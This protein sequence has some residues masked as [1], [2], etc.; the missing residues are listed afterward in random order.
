MAT[1]Q[2]RDLRLDHPQVATPA[3]ACAGRETF[4]EMLRGLLLGHTRSVWRTILPLPRGQCPASALATM[5][6]IS[7]DVLR[8]DSSTTCESLRASFCVQL[9]DTCEPAVPYLCKESGVPSFIGLFLARPRH[10]SALA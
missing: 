1:W 10:H 3:I 2:L 4:R 7:R 8:A 5:R 9:R 6:A